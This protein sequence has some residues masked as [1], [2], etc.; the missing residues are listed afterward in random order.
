MAEAKT[1]VREAEP[2]V[3]SKALDGARRRAAA[4]GGV[5]EATQRAMYRAM[6][7]ARMTDERCWL[8]NRGGKAPFVISCQGQEGAQVG[9]VF[10]LDREQ[11]WFVPY[12]R[13]LAVVMALGMTPEDIFK[14]V[15]GRAGEPNSGAR[16]MPSHFG[17]R[18]LRIVSQGSSVATQCLHAV[19]T[20]LAS[21][22]RGEKAVS[23]CYVG[24]GGTS[25]GDFHEALNFASV[26]RLPVIM[27]VEN[28]QYAISVPQDLQMA[29]QDVAIRAAGYG[30]PGFVV[31]GQDVF[32]VHRLTSDA[33]A[34]ARAGEGPTLIEAKTHRLT[35][36]SS[37][38]D[39]RVYRPAEEI[40]QEASE[41]AVPRFRNQLLKA[42][43]ITEEDDKAL[44]AELLAEIDAATEAAEN[45]PYPAP[46]ETLLHVYGEGGPEPDEL[47]GD[48]RA[49]LG[50]EA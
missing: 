47:R 22:I 1:R 2:A 8:L 33:A 23:I 41:D 49:D 29:V 28:N 27:F 11:D 36:H 40:K 35:S 14:S 43:V 24:E 4:A 30:I 25:Q 31:D 37:D 19:G 46:E 48:P 10:A 6:L 5:D 44:R 20:A 39:Q 38:D 26:H 42:G 15:M 3:T 34:R 16:Q 12:Y 45:A 9:S 32:E 21:K 18:K 17:S 7:M 13:D 50:G